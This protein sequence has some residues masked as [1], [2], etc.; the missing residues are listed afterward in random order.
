MVFDFQDTHC[1]VSGVCSHK[2]SLPPSTPE[3]PLTDRTR[4]LTD[5]MCTSFNCQRVCREICVLQ[6]V[7]LLEESPNIVQTLRQT[8]MSPYRIP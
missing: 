3:L 8:R 6:R 1:V 7:A 2:I 4:S 5:V